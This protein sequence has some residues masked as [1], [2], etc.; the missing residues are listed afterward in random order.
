M[1]IAETDTPNVARYDEALV[2]LEALIVDNPDFE[3]LE[4]LL[5]QFNIFEAVGVVRQEVRHSNFLA[6][7]LDP[8]QPHG[9]GD[10]TAKLLLQRSLRG[11]HNDLPVSPIDLHLWNLDSMVVLR[12]WEN[13]D[14]LL[15]DELA[16]LAVII[17]NK[18]DSGERPDQLAR[19]RKTVIRHYPGVRTL[20]L[21]LTPEGDLPS[22]EF[23]TPVSYS[24]V[25]RLVEDLVQSRRSTLG[26]D[27]LTLMTHYARTLRRH[28]VGDAEIAELCQR[29]YAKHQRALDLIYEHRPDQQVVIR[30][31][32]EQLII[33]APDLVLDQSSKSSIR[34]VPRAWHIPELQ[35]GTGEWAGTS[36]VLLFEFDN[37]PQSLRLRLIIG[38]GPVEIRRRLFDEYK[39]L[40]TYRNN[41]KSL[42]PKFHTVYSRAI[43]KDNASE[44]ISTDDIYREMREKWDRFLREDFP[45][46]VEAG[47]KSAAGPSQ[48]Q[49]PMPTEGA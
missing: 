31:L 48:V 13:I 18:I 19:Y 2:L 11:R 12:E 7:L 20:G 10:L 33:E 35:T 45:K 27:V 30:E 34:F 21:F 23:Y 5:D 46:L 44:N 8:R 24:L 29:I 40:Q 36:C 15:L 17:E 42:S 47:V 41:S 32:L 22:D 28:V 4:V 25:A 39:A 26:S 37:K 43:L 1:N 49:G 3:R 9:M 38:P 6:F 14:I 16:G